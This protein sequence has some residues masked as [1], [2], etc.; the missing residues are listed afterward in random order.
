MFHFP[1]F[2]SLSLCVQQRDTVGLPTVGFP[3]RK[4]PDQRVFAAPR[5]LSQLT[6]SF[7][8]YRCQGIR[9]K[10]LVA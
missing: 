8:D 7:I 1:S 10:P 4:S 6:T 3:I 9:R 2:A 5:G